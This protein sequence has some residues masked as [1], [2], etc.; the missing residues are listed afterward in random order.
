VYVRRYK[1]KTGQI[2]P[3]LKKVKFLKSSYSANF[4]KYSQGNLTKIHNYMLGVVVFYQ[5]EEI[6]L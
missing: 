4:K 6:T 1:A 2:W 5:N 3:I